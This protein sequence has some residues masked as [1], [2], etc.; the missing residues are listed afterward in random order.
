[1]IIAFGV[2]YFGDKYSRSSFRRY[3]KDYFSRNP[4][5]FAQHMELTKQIGRAFGIDSSPDDSIETYVAKVMRALGLDPMN[6]VV[7]EESKRTRR[8]REMAPLPGR[9][10]P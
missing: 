6:P 7:T 10:E 8:L 1:V 2:Y 5:N 3:L 4:F 9:Q